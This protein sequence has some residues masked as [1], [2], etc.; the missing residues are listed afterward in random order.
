MTTTQT[1]KPR[2]RLQMRC[3]SNAS[4]HGYQQEGMPSISQHL[5]GPFLDFCA[6]LRTYLLTNLPDAVQHLT[7]T[8]SKFLRLVYRLPV[9]RHARESVLRP[10][11]RVQCTRW[12]VVKIDGPDP[13]RVGCRLSTGGVGSLGRYDNGGRAS[14]GPATDSADGNLLTLLDHFF[15]CVKASE[16]RTF[17]SLETDSRSAALARACAL[18]VS[19]FCSATLVLATSVVYWL[20]RF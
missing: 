10:D 5:L 3:V 17:G 18:A 14:G 4:F 19:S 12:S 2:Y 1:P 16:E 20:I 7:P 9:H 6:V 8:I 13:N 15:Q 11:L